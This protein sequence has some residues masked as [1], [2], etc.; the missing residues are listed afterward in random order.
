[1]RTKARWLKR[2]LLTVILYAASALA[3]AAG[4]VVLVALILIE[5]MDDTEE[6]DR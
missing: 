1:M 4:A 3:L 5:D 6:S 2:K